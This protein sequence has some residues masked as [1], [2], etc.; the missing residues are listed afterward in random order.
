MTM[1]KNRAQKIRRLAISELEKLAISIDQEFEITSNM[2]IEEME[3]ELLEMGVDLRHLHS[4]SLE[5]ML[6][7][8]PL[9][10]SAAYAYVSDDLRQGE[11]ITSEVK[12]LILQ[13]RY[14]GRQ[15][16]YEEA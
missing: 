14:L 5:Q 7:G 15:H 16:R 13:L 8:K 2:P 3:H 4:L 9:S 6:A 10:T 12:E 11:P 1:A